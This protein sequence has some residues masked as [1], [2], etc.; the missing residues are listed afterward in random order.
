MTTSKLHTLPVLL[1]ALGVMAL[2]CIVLLWASSRTPHNPEAD[3][4]R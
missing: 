1:A 4:G 3:E 2:K